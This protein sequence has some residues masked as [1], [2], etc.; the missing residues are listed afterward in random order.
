MRMTWKR[1]WHCKKNYFCYD[2]IDYVIEKKL[3]EFVVQFIKQADL[4]DRHTLIDVCAEG[5]LET[6]Q[7][8]LDEVPFT[9]GVLLNAASSHH[10]ICS[11]GNFLYLLS[12]IERE[13]LRDNA[14]R[15]A[16][17]KWYP[18][19]A[20]CAGRAL[21]ALESST[22][23]SKRVKDSAVKAAFIAAVSNGK[24]S[25]VERLYDHPAITPEEYTEGLYTAWDPTGKNN[26]VFSKLLERADEADLEMALSGKCHCGLG[27]DMA[28]EQ[29]KGRKGKAA[30]A[31]SR[32]ST[33]EKAEAARKVV[34]ETT[35]TPLED[36]GFGDIIS[37]YA[38]VRPTDRIPGPN[39]QEDCRR[40]HK[41]PNSAINSRNQ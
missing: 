34:G 7:K 1:L 27:K 5:S 8:V 28:R 4:V 15:S 36:V 17:G 11:P 32:Q 10:L 40:D 20:D 22:L 2:E 3:P 38:T 33:R 18:K 37:G 14:V 35:E 31:G 24:D 6:V 13:Y 29:I 39:C 23:M 21:D 30:P 12:R 25:L 26:Q 9:E 16:F 41:G 19:N